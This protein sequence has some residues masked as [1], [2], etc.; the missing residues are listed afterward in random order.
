MA[1]LIGAEMISSNAVKSVVNAMLDKELIAQEK[2]CFE[3][4]DNFF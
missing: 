4:C 3:I 2:R 1:E